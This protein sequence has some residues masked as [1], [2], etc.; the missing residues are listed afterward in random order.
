MILQDEVV[1]GPWEE[2]LFLTPPVEQDKPWMAGPVWRDQDHIGSLDPEFSGY[3]SNHA[4]GGGGK[5]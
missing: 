5:T 1:A 3:L 4:E 2:P